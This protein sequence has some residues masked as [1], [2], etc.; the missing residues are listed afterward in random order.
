[1]KLEMMKL[2]MLV[3]GSCSDKARDGEARDVMRLEM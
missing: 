2:G 1:M 3:P